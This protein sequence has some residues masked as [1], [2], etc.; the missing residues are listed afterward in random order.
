MINAAELAAVKSWITKRLHKIYLKLRHLVA[1]VVP[2][3]LA[4]DWEAV[5]ARWSEFH[6]LM[7][8]GDRFIEAL[9]A[10]FGITVCYTGSYDLIVKML[11]EKWLPDQ[12]PYTKETTSMDD[13]QLEPWVFQS[14]FAKGTSL[15]PTPSFFPL[16]R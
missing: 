13:I 8:G 10:S 1:I 6:L 16:S 7:D 15:S 5:W 4:S 2:D 14:L 9:C 11:D 3:K 12:D